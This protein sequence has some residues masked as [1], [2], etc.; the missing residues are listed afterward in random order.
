MQVLTD[1]YQ[2]KQNSENFKKGTVI[3]IGNF[4]GIHLGHRCLLQKNIELS[5]KLNS[6]SAV[7]TFDPHP[8]KFFYPEKNFESLFDK[9]DQIEQLSRFGIDILILIKFDQNFAAISAEEFVDLLKKEFNLKGLVLGANFCFGA[10]RKGNIDFLKNMQSLKKFELVVP[11]MQTINNEIIST[12]LIKKLLNQGDVVKANEFLARP[13]S[14]QG[15]VE[16]GDQRGRT[17]GF[18][19]ANILS[20]KALHLK[21]GVYKTK[22]QIVNNNLVVE[23]FDAITNVGSNPTVTKQ[24]PIIKIESHLFNFSKDIYKQNIRI[25]FYN[26]IREEKKFNSIDELKEQIKN[27]VFK[28][29]GMS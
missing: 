12:T 6:L 26:F 24:S 7:V 14:I 22:V 20:S 3:S 2:F 25:E 1:V 28:V 4:D 10:E 17:I 16:Y 29:R 9:E 21:K 8:V 5:R 13:F 23:N 15:K 11:E 18:P 27:D 19:T